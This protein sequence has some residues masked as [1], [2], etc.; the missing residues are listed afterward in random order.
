MR[1]LIAPI[2]NK[3]SWNLSNYIMRKRYDVA[4]IEAKK[5][6]QKVLPRVAATLETQRAQGGLSHQFSELKLLEL[7]EYLWRFRPKTILELGGGGTTAVLAEYAASESGVQVVS[8]DESQHY[9]DA[10]RERLDIKV[11][12]KIKFTHCSRKEEIDSNGDR[13]CFYDDAWKKMFHASAVDLVYVDGP[14]TD[15]GSGGK[16]PCTDVVRLC[17]DGWAVGHVLFDVRIASV[18]Y[19]VA[20]G[21]FDSHHFHLHRNALNSAKEPWVVDTV[22]HHSWLEP[23]PIRITEAE[24]KKKID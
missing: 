1:K 13:T 17:D 4:C 24:Q 16:L 9:L 6:L 21:R 8:V 10:T 7:A 20:S 23:G 11:S 3:V 22:R 12:D 15:D 19:C 18:K 5:K 2:A 14:S